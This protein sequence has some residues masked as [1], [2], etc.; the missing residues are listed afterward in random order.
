MPVGS[1]LRA[2]YEGSVDRRSFTAPGRASKT[3]PKQASSD[4]GFLEWALQGSNL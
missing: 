1:Y 4:Q 2:C 3:G